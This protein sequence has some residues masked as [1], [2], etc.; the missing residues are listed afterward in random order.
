MVLVSAVRMAVRKLIRSCNRG[1]DPS[2][3]ETQPE[4][5]T[6]HEGGNGTNHEAQWG[7]PWH[8]NIEQDVHDIYHEQM[9]EEDDMDEGH[10]ESHTPW[11]EDHEEDPEKVDFRND[12]WRH[13]KCSR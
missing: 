10:D 8:T 9:K 13:M 3:G 5:G 2:E 11:E 4:G 7:D 6:V 1:E 12:V